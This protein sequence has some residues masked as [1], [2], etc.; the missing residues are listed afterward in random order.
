MPFIALRERYMISPYF[1]FVSSFFD[2]R[3]KY[4]ARDIFSLMI[5]L[6]DT[7]TGSISARGTR[8]SLSDEDKSTLREAVGLCMEI[9][10]K[11]GKKQEDIFLGTVNAGHPGGMLPLKESDQCTLHNS[12]LPSN[13]YVADATILPKSLG[14]P[15]ILT[16]AALAKRIGKICAG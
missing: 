3:W 13:L 11:M 7:N 10:R 8:K 9:F 5:K 14:S 16:I 15:A 2:R 12:S 4:P 6:A 1:D